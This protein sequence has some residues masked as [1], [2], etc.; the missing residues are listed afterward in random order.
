M[1][2]SVAS[3]VNVADAFELE[4][5]LGILIYDKTCLFRKMKVKIYLFLKVWLSFKLL[6]EFAAQ[7]LIVWDY[8]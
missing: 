6:E 5:F 3:R 4:Q 1:Q 2:P 8:Y 7:G